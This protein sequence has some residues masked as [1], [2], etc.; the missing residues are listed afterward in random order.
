M[1]CSVQVLAGVELAINEQI[2]EKDER[3]QLQDEQLNKASAMLQH[4]ARIKQDQDR[5]MAE[6]VRMLNSGANPGSVET[7]RKTQN[8]HARANEAMQAELN[9]SRQAM[10][11]L[12]LSNRQLRE[13]GASAD[14]QRSKKVKKSKSSASIS[15]RF[16]GIFRKSRSSR[17]RNG[18]ATQ[19][20]SVTN[21][22]EGQGEGAPMSTLFD[23]PGI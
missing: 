11:E 9:A 3:L 4:A 16:S 2:R 10:A 1:G 8:Y 13:A 23:T 5:K 21:H 12:D 15:K 20:I 14:G 6:M 7:M 18:S 19:S 22:N 17:K